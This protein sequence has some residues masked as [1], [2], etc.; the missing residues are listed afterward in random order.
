MDMPNDFLV[1]AGAAMV[2]LAKSKRS[3]VLYNLAKGIG[4]KRE[5]GTPRFP[6]Q[7]MPMGLV[8]YAADFF[9]AEDMNQVNWCISIAIHS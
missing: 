6:T 8:E 1:Y 2:E 7:Q 5:D 4:T 3:N 9:V